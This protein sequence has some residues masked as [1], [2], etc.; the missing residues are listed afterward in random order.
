MRLFLILAFCL[1]PSSLVA[2]HWRPSNDGDHHDAVVKITGNNGWSGSGTVVDFIKDSEENSDYYIGLI[3]TASHVVEN[4]DILF[5]VNFNNGCIT[6]GG[7]VIKKNSYI[8]DGF[9]DIAIIRALIPDSV[10]PMELSAEKPECGT[11]LELAGFGASQFRHWLAPYCGT[12]YNQDGLVVFSWA[13]QGDS[14]GPVIYKGKVIGVICFGTS[15]KKYGDTSR[16]IVGPVYGTSAS[17]VM[18]FIKDYKANE[19]S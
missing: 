17:R 7:K 3:I 14:G 13:I 2:Q 15:I 18:K 8:M 16:L 12:V 4:S 1:V 11:E 5:K 19:T 9:N 10:K 6:D